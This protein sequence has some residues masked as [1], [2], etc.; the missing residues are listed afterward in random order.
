MSR[1]TFNSDYPSVNAARE[2]IDCYFSARNRHF[3]E[4][5]RRAGSKI[6]GKERTASTF[7]AA[8]NCKDGAY[9]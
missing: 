4:N 6:W 5:P 2:A 7:D 8:H 3:T 1:N 9:R